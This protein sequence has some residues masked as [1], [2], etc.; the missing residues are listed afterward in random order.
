MRPAA[1]TW[2]RAVQLLVHVACGLFLASLLNLDFSHRLSCERLSRWWCRRLLAILHVRVQVQGAA[3][4]G[5]HVTA[6]NHVSWLDII[7]LT[8]CGSSRF[9]AKSE[10]RHWPVAGW[11]AQAMGTFYIRRGK[12]GARPLLERLTPHLHAGGSVTFFPEGTTTDGQAVLEF[13]PRLFAAAV[14]SGCPVQPVALQYGPAANGA[15][16]APFIGDDDLLRHLLRLLREPEL[17]AWLSYCPPIPGHGQT[18]EALAT[19]SRLAIQA[20]L[21]PAARTAPLACAAPLDALAA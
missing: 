1:R 6:A 5:G 3:V 15:Q 17:H 7:L 20:A 9:I 10:I 8:S 18:R 12:G 4:N 16:I 21:A 11:L 14:E 13:H 2:L 19:R